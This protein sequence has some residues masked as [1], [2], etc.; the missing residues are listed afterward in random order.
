MGAHD[1]GDGVGLEAAGGRD[2]EALAEALRVDLRLD[3]RPHHPC[4]LHSVLSWHERRVRVPC[5]MPLTRSLTKTSHS[6]GKAESHMSMWTLRRWTPRKTFPSATRGR[7]STPNME[8][9]SMKA[10][11]SSEP[12]LYTHSVACNND[13]ECRSKCLR[14]SLHDPGQ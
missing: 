5:I 7:S 13:E 9:N 1:E 12:G 2:L 8:M 3:V 4:K 10:D 11:D 6:R 14:F